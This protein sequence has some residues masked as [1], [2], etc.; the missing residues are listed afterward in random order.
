M[1]T[2][3]IKPSFR[4]SWF[5]GTIVTAFKEENR[6]TDICETKAFMLSLF[7]VDFTYIPCVG[8]ILLWKGR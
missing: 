6:D 7:S 8:A 4:V 1:E 3:S 5:M 2:G